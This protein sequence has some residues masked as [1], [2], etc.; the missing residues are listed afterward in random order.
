MPHRLHVCPI[1]G[2]AGRAVQV[3]HYR[4]QGLSVRAIAEVLK[5]TFQTVHIYLHRAVVRGLMPA[6]WCARAPRPATMV[7]KG[8]PKP[9]EEEKGLLDKV[10]GVC[11]RALDAATASL[12]VAMAKMNWNRRSSMDFAP[13]YKEPAGLRK[14]N[15]KTE[16]LRIQRRAA[17]DWSNLPQTSSPTPAN[18]PLAGHPFTKI[19][20]PAL[21][22]MILDALASDRE[23]A[24]SVHRADRDMTDLCALFIAREELVSGVVAGK[25][26]LDIASRT[27]RL[28]RMPPL[29]LLDFFEEL[30]R[31]LRY[32][33]GVSH[34]LR[35]WQIDFADLPWMFMRRDDLI[36]NQDILRTLTEKA[37]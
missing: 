36:R 15:A 25:S 34:V 14:F 32:D 26:P 23:V 16:E 31:P 35:S 19:Q 12:G 29:Q 6:E 13:E 30:F 37:V 4:S 11:A 18:R 21:S 27:A 5:V 1:T 3:T 28:R 22:A 7:E 9:D 17:F 10:R 8:E 33:T 2:I 20:I 24:P